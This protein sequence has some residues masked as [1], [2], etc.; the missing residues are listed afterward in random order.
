MERVKGIG[1]SSSA[2][3]A[4]ALPLSY[5]RISIWWGRKESNLLTSKGTDLQS[6]A[7]LQLS[8]FPKI[9][10]ISRLDVRVKHSR[11]TP[12][13]KRHA[14]SLT[15]ICGARGGTRTPNILDLNQAPLPIGLHG[16]KLV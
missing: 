2:W 12:Y 15:H 6:A 14:S 4:V 13:T 10:N 9:M 1:P 16:H 8:R 11:Q 7:A 5:T 3:K